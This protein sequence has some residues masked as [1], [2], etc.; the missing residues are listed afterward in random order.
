MKKRN[1]RRKIEIKH[2]IPFVEEI[3]GAKGVKIVKNI[4]KRGATDSIIAKRTSLN[5]S[6]IRAIL[7]H[8]HSFGVT[9]Y[10]KE[11]NMETGWY[12]YT[13]RVNPERALRNFLVFKKKQYNELKR[14]IEAAENTVIYKCRK[15]CGTYTFEEAVEND[16]LCPVCNTEL[17][18]AKNEEI[19]NM[20]RESRKIR[21]LIRKN[22]FIKI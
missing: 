22:N 6:E 11:K 5:I 18:E 20:K 9:D 3:I 21:E 8:L 2:I 14:K 7:N 1:S 16:F 10:S 15:G 17:K 19:Q 13:W 12:T 4:G